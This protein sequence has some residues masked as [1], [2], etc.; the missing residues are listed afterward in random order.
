MKY[1]EFT[2]KLQAKYGDLVKWHLPHGKKELF[3][4]NPDHI[5]AVLRHDG[6]V[7]ERAPIDAWIKVQ[8][9]LGVSS[10]LITR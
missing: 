9:Q 8:K 3:L 5:K 10:S 7:P 4:F 1:H 6:N 2:I